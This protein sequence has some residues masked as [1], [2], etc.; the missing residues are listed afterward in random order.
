MFNLDQHGNHQLITKLTYPPN[1]QAYIACWV[2]LSDFSELS[3]YSKTRVVT[4]LTFF[5]SKT[6]FP[7]L[8]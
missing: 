7:I 8:F 5:E 2:Q 4:F 1:R 3:G 6:L